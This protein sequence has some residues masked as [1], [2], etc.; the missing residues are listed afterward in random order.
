MKTTRT[1][2]LISVLV[3]LSMVICCMSFA[4]ADV[5]AVTVNDN[6]SG[7]AIAGSV[8]ENDG[9]TWDNAT[10]YF[11]LTDRFKNG[12][13]SNDH[14]YGRT[15]DKDGKPISGW[16]TAPGT[17]HGGDFAGIT[18]A[19]EEGYFSGLGVNALWS[20]GPYE[21]THGYC[22]S[23]KGFAHYSYHGYYVLE[24]TETYANCGTP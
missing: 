15:L 21:Q 12:N 19:I 17:F 5:S 3:A 23:G 8:V 13:T 14:S 7:S 6:A 10:V 16:D 9:F 2:K 18:Q 4:F 1:V 20:S 11:M 24:Y 22:G